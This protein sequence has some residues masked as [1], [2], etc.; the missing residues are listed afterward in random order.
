MKTLFTL[1]I[2][3]TIL[4]QMH[5]QVN[6]QYE[7]SAND[8]LFS[9][10]LLVD[11][12]DFFYTAVSEDQNIYSTHLVLW[13]ATTESIQWS[14]KLTVE[15]G[16]SMLPVK[17]LRRKDGT[18]ILGATDYSSKDGFSNGNYTFIHID[19]KGNI[20]NTRRLGSSTG[21][22]LRDLILDDNEDIIFLGDRINS[23]S[24]YRT[25]LG[26]LDKDLNVVAMRSVFKEYYTYGFA[27][28]KDSK[29]HI[30]TVGHTQPATFGFKRSMVT[31]WSNDLDHVSTLIQQDVDPNTTFNYIYI[32]EDDKIHLGGNLSNLP[33]Y[34]RLSN[35]LGY[36]YG[37]EFFYSY[38]KNIWKD[39]NG[40]VNIFVEG[41]NSYGVFDKEDNLTFKSVLTNIGTNNSQTYS[42][43]KNW[44]YNLSHFNTAENPKNRLLLNSN[45][46]KPDNECFLIDRIGGA[47]GKLRIDSFGITDVVIRNE[48]MTSMTP[49][50]I[51]IVDYD[52]EV[53]EVCRI[54]IISST[55]Q[56]KPQQTMRV[57]PNP[58]HEF[59]Q[60]DLPENEPINEA[61]LYNLQGI[62]VLQK[63]NFQRG[64][65]LNISGL[66]A[67]IYTV[68]LQTSTG[69]HL[70]SKFSI[71]R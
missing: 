40:L 65:V 51:N 57:Y 4:A 55:A 1:F 16:V 42:L 19:S 41:T 50:D 67:G 53:K 3:L 25:V 2:T 52:L 62:C 35:D 20:L 6:Y 64:D 24:A 63:S 8:G 15:Q 70:I 13:N 11:G 66:S 30:F 43:D 71:I 17:I 5:A 33:T 69:Y 32:D 39:K 31:K 48:M 49:N 10:H 58:A 28:A 14:K 7:I 23:Q 27:L 18:C 45:S 44:I 54:E 61:Y 68:R 56:E 37:H 9:E 47:Q 21:G 36:E 12:A 34:V 38:I 29:G 22:I 59:I 60:F 46:L 26:R